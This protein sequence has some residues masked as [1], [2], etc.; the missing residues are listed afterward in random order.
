MRQ[1]INQ[2]FNFFDF[3]KVLNNIMS[4]KI[5][6]LVVDDEPDVLEIIDYNLNLNGYE[7]YTADNGEECRL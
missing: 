5:K 4:T 2:S 3:K 1:R 7:V 6:I